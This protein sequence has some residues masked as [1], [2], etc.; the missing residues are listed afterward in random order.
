MGL[1]LFDLAGPQRLINDGRFGFA[2]SIAG[3]GQ[4]PKARNEICRVFLDQHPGADWLFSVDSDMGF[5]QDI[6]ERLLASADPVERPVMGGLCFGVRT[7]GVG[8]AQA[9]RSHLFPTIYRWADSDGNYGFDP[10]YDYP[11]DSI[12]EVAGTGAACILIHRSVLE[13]IRDID[14]ER[15]FDVEPYRDG[16]F[17]EDLS[18]CR[19]VRKHGFKVHVNT[20]ARTSHKKS[21]WIDEQFYDLIRR[22]SS[23]RSTYVVIPV[24]DQ[25]E[26]TRRV[27]GELVQ[28]GHYEKIFI[29]DNGSG[30]ETRAWLE[31][32][33]V[34]E[35]FDAAGAN[36]HEMWNAGIDMAQTATP[37]ADVA[38]LNNDLELGPDFLSLMSTA[39]HSDPTL[40]AVSANYDGRTFP[41]DV[42][43]QAG[44]C[45]GRYDGSGGFAGFAFM[46][47][48]DFLDSGYRFPEELV[49]W[50]GDND[51]LASIEAAGG[52]YAVAKHAACVHLDGGSVTSR[53]LD[54]DE[55]AAQCEA[56][57]VWFREKWL[58]GDD[59]SDD[60]QP[61]GSFMD[62]ASSH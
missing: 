2:A 26:M 34:A 3:A 20:G 47:R 39:L 12:C 19:R 36:I 1:E 54:S 24:K 55:F 45:A 61:A 21:W 7:A 48:G 5:D 32:Q 38:I 51:M 60:G 27:V 15:W 49:W 8:A 6:L 14:G 18:F 29:F 9:V 28:Q 10:V 22:Q 58:G 13:K 46:V 57:G 30:P 44:I 4:L 37:G 62:V 40:L 17:S 25:L 35:V 42:Q 56:D 16:W 41:G 43:R 52:W 23:G 50:Y 31:A 59:A 11:R 53:T 33:D